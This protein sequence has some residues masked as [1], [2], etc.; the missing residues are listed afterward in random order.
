MEEYIFSTKA[1]FSSV[2]QNGQH[3]Q[4]ACRFLELIMHPMI[5]FGY[6]IEFGLPGMMIEGTSTG[7]ETMSFTNGYIVL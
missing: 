7:Y 3:P 2:S 6:G 5:H 4:M 1:N